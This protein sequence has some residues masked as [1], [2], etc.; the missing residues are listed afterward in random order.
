M[1]AMVQALRRTME[2]SIDGH[3]ASLGD[4]DDVDAPFDVAEALAGMGLPYAH[5]ALLKEGH[6]VY[7]KIKEQLSAKR[8]EWAEK[9]QIPARVYLGEWEIRALRALRKTDLKEEVSRLGDNVLT[10]AGVELF[11]TKYGFGSNIIIA[12]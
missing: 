10:V 4:S 12:P 11:V 6:A 2:I 9:G 1:L 7:D 8:V 5:L 3:E